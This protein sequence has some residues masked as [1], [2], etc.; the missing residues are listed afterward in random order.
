MAGG[1]CVQFFSVVDKLILKII[2]NGTGVAQT[3]AL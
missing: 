1:I 2:F 3:V